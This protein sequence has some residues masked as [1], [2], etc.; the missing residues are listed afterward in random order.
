MLRVRLMFGGPPPLADPASAGGTLGLGR[1]GGGAAEH[2]SKTNRKHISFNQRRVSSIR[3]R[4]GKRRPESLASVVGTVLGLLALAWSG[5][6][7]DV[8]HCGAS[9]TGRR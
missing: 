8:S 4:S 3:V 6:G 1:G 2:R 9:V 7:A 5:V